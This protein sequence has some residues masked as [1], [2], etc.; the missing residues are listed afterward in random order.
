VR[1]A[2]AAAAPAATA[3][4]PSTEVLFWETIKASTDPADFRAYL[5]QFPNGSFAALARNRVAALT[6]EKPAARSAAPPQLAA[7]APPA[8]APV[9]PPA[10]PVL[11]APPPAAPAPPAAKPVVAAAPLSGAFV[12]PKP[13]TKLL[14]STGG[15]L[16]VAEVTGHTLGL[17]NLKGE[18]QPP[19]V[20]LFFRPG[21]E[22]VYDRAIIESIWP[23]EVGKRVVTKVKMSN[24]GE[25]ALSLHVVRTETVETATGHYEC[26]LVD[27]EIDRGHGRWIGR[28]HNWYAPS[29]GFIVRN[30]LEMIA[31]ERPP[32]YRDWELAG[33]IKP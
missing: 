6:T 25:Y 11:A 8:V 30:R 21:P 24:G 4:Q 1:A 22:A 26:F 13:G 5:E 31:G 33:L 7:A 16:Q 12:A 28:F 9:P 27:V 2:S 23:L 10:K 29:L 3:A 14:L 20:G 19:L 15:G 32:N 18:P 17:T